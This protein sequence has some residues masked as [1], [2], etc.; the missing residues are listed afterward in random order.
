MTIGHYINGAAVADTDAR[1]HPVYDPSTGEQHS[2]V[3]LAS[4]ARTGEAIAAAQAAFAGWA[5]TAP[6][7]R[8][9]ILFR[10]KE[11]CEAH[12]DELCAAITQEHGK[13]LSDARGELTRGIEVVEFACGIPHLLKGEHAENVGSGVDSWSLMQP[14]GVTAGITPFNFPAM[15]P[16]WMFPVAIACGNT[17]VLKPSEKDP[18]AAMLMAQLLTEA[19]LPDGVFNVVNGDKE[20]VDVLL[21]DAR[22]QAVSFVGSTPIAEYIYTKGCAHGK[23]VQALGGAKNHLAVAPD[24]DLEQVASALLGSAY[25]SAGERCMAISVAVCMGDQVADE[26]LARLTP[27]VQGLK[28]GRGT[29]PEAEMGPLVS[30]QHLARVRGYVDQGV[31]EGASLV[32]DGRASPAGCP[33]G[34]YFMSGCLF[35]HVTDQMRIYREEIFGPVLSVVRAPDY[36]SACRLINQHEYGNG[37]SIFTRSGALARRFAHEI[38]VGMVGVNV[39]IPVPMAFFSFGGWKRS[40]FGPLNMH[41]RD[42]VRFYTRMKTVTARWPERLASEFI[43]PTM[44]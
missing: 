21:E 32:V 14:L 26:L 17:F 40:V 43:M 31:A 22:V 7:R 42:G 24:A 1:Q 23:R 36:E 38:Q 25:G 8:A 4:A 9:R 5:N 12:A 3:A 13:V 6:I 10:F 33:A 11:L 19:G 35:D 27:M 37:T 20:A 18:S 41:G 2:S 34:G 28:I 30:A 39:P 15:V 44:G 29:E 16:M